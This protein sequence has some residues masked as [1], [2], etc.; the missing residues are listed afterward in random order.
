MLNI[1][2]KLRL[3]KSSGAGDKYLEGGD[4]ILLTESLYKK[5]NKKKNTPPGVACVFSHVI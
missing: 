5:E 2:S 1:L 3:S 4:M